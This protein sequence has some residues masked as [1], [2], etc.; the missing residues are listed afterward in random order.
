[1]LLGAA[2][3]L[4]RHRDELRGTVKFLFQPAEELVG[5]HGS[6]AKLMV[7]QG[8]MNNPKVDCVIGIHIIGNLPSRTFGVRSGP[9]TSHSDP[10]WI[11][12]T[13]KGGHQ[14]APDKTVDP[15]FIG[16]Q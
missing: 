13:G 5:P 9:V 1:M 15:L 10:F 2:M 14:S 6:G 3:L 11:T 8:V 4:A 12:I 16:V 7:E